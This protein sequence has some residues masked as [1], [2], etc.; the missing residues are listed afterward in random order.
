[1]EDRQRA[2][3]MEYRKRIKD[4]EDRQKIK[5]SKINKEQKR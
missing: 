4:I 5:I 2:E 1:M 3:D